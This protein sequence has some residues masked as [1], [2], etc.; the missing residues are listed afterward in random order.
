[1]PLQKI[2]FK[3]GVN[4]EGT[5]LAN[6][7]GWFD[8]DKIRFRSGYPEKIGGWVANGFNTFLGTCRSLWNW[9]T[10]SQNNLLGVGT[11]V[12]FYIEN[13]GTYNDITPIRLTTTNTTTFALGKSSLNAAINAT[14]TTIP[15][16][17]AGIGIALPAEGAIILIDY[18]QI[19]YTTRTGTTLNGCIRGINGTTATSH[20]SGARVL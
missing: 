2:R 6:E 13:G 8:G 1:M 14:Q 3:P 7:G 9:I 10:L 17:T 20:A 12:K 15:L 19:E 18:E 11:N 5:S 4:R 16:F